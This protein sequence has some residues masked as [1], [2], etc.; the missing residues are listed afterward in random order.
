MFFFFCSP[1]FPSESEDDEKLRLLYIVMTL[2]HLVGQ[3][4]SREDMPLVDQGL[5]LMQNLL[6]ENR[7]RVAESIE[8]VSF[9]V[10]KVVSVRRLM[11]TERAAAFFF[12]FKCK[13]F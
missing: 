1:L 3:S 5:S 8:R 2:T 13:L 7:D 6:S 11:L 10:Q 4:Q 9:S 12:F